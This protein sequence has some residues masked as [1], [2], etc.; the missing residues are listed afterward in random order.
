LEGGVP[1]REARDSTSAKEAEAPASPPLRVGGS[2]D[3]RVP[4]READR[5]A[6]TGIGDR[7]HFAVRWV[8][9]EEVPVPAASISLRY[10][11]RRELIRL[12][13]LT[14]D[15]EL[16]ARE[17]GRGFEREYAPDPGRR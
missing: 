7:V 1:S 4:A 15:G 13:V 2:P 11:F 3:S 6:A 17:R 9:F 10:E 8:D 16:Y 12:G 5:F 14:G